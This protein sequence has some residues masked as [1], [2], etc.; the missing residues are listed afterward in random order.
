MPQDKEQEIKLRF[1]EEAQE[2]VNNIE[3]ELLG[4][5]NRGVESKRLD[6]VLRAAHSI[7]GGAAMMGFQ[8]LSHLA[9]RL[10]DFF[11]V[12]KVRKSEVVDEDLES[13]LLSSV[14]HLHQIIALNRQGDAVEEKWLDNH[15]VPVFDQLHELLGTPQAEDS[16]TLLSDETGE[17]M[18]VLLFETEVEGCLQRLE[19]VLAHPEQ[20]CLKEE[21]LITAQELG[22]L[23]EMLELADF[24]SLCESIV[25]HLETTPEQ[26]KEITYLAIQEWRRSQALV[27]A[28]QTTNLPTQIDLVNLNS[29]GSSESYPA[30]VDDI[31]TLESFED[32]SLSF[33]TLDSFLE[34]NDFEEETVEDFISSLDTISDGE[35]EEITIENLEETIVVTPSTSSSPKLEPQRQSPTTT[36]VSEVSERTI[37]V[38]VKHLAQLSD[39]FGELIIE[40]NGLNLQ[41]NNLRNLLGSL[42]QRVQFLE[43]SNFRL[44]N[45]YNQ[46]VSETKF[47][48]NHSSENSNTRNRERK[49][50]S[51]YQSF[52]LLEMDNFSDV[53]LLSQEVM[54]T[55]VQIQEV[56]SDIEINLEDAE[57]TTRAFNR[58]SQQMQTNITEVRM[59]PISDLLERF[60]R[61]LRDMALEYGK[62]V[63]LKVKGGSTLIDRTILE[64][65]N[66]PLLHLFRN[67]FDHGIENPATRRACGK[68]EQGV[69]EISAIHRGNQTVITIRD[70]GGGIDIAKIR[71]QVITMGLAEEDINK[72]NDDELLDLIFEPGFST[73]G[74]V[75]GLSGRGVGMDV[76]RT[77]LQQVRGSI[78]VD[79]KPNVGTTFTITVPFTLSVVRVLLVESNGLLLAFPTNSIKEMLLLH[80]KQVTLSDGREIL[81]WRESKVPII[82]LSQW[83]KF[84]RTPPKFN[85][86]TAPA[87]NEESILI[88]SEDNEL[89][90]IQIDRYWGEQ[91]VTIRQVEG[92]MKM[93]PGFSGCT[94]L[95]DG[96]VVPLID[97]SDL[98]S[99]IENQQSIHNST[100]ET[101]N[102]LI[103][104]PEQL[105][106]NQTNYPQKDVVMVVDDSINVRRFLAV[107]LE[108]A[109]YRIEQ[110]KD[111][112]EA[113]EKLQEGLPVQL[114][115]CDIEMPRLDGYG[116]LAYVKSN[117]TYKNTPVVMLTSRSG[118]RHR[119]IAM[120]LGASAYFSKPFQEHIL[121]QTLRE[122][123]QTTKNLAQ[124]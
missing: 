97:P 37:R 80:S 25:Q 120:N 22:G 91:E 40:R 83:L 50:T 30:Q 51:H 103:N 84:A 48:F 71:A 85:R 106:S 13:L 99:S 16:A 124:L 54:E 42:R 82:R 47:N 116:F 95:G 9:H 45:T 55:I 81:D 93:P 20:P 86:Q 78:H 94:I 77:N 5:G 107:T 104:S 118:D 79:T 7:K 29:P 27:M 88:V 57:Y 66:D 109:D 76:V 68:P 98:I 41:L 74:R 19:A 112:Q 31:P 18:T 46:F 52:D 122:L 32:L 4:L 113:L 69:I 17:D 12:L 8:S 35:Q 101:Q 1:L 121:L 14:D 3:S 89:K 117:P 43:R 44:H 38:P 92:I 60:P 108:K 33:D 36:I 67:A 100:P 39:L 24:S 110:A 87:I 53:D 28:R 21:F 73:A 61:A 34:S 56:T 90:A 10:E 105:S 23:G 58:T 70:D 64:A 49:A 115:V 75:T 65:L 2:Y 11:K 59:R 119:K 26:V 102:S 114:I 72:A 96:R 6:G 62:Q 123:I 63:E 111:G 15:P